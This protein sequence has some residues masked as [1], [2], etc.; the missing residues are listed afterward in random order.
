MRVN[1][2]GLR[3]YGA[4]FVQ[5]RVFCSSNKPNEPQEIRK[6]ILI[7]YSSY[8]PNIDFVIDLIAQSQI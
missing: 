7:C 1:L 5:H 8:I 6:A 3:F 4:G 2:P